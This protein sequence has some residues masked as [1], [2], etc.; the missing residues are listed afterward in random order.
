ML[1]GLLGALAVTA[2]GCGGPNP[3]PPPLPP[4]KPP[5][6]DRAIGPLSGLLTGAGLQWLVLVKPARL[7]A[8]EWLQQPLGRILKRERLAL[9]AR[10]TGIDVRRCAELTLAGYQDD[11]VAYLV[12]HRSD[13]TLVE[14]RFRER[15]TSDVQR[16]EIDR[17][18]LGL[19]GNIGTKPHGFAALGPDVAAF[20]YGGDKKRGPARIALLYAQGKLKKVP[21]ALGGRW[22]GAAHRALGDAPAKLLLPGP[23]E[24]EMAAGLRGLLGGATA[25]GAALTP[26]RS[27]SLRF[28][29]VLT[30]SWPMDAP[31]GERPLD[32]L[33][34][35]WLDL[36]KSDLGHLL[37]L[38]E[39]LSEPLL[40]AGAH[41]L[42][43]AVE[44]DAAKLFDGLAAATLDDVREFMRAP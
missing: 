18:L 4:P 16:A 38:H 17:Q 2:L 33:R 13:Q 11:V 23:F 39:P 9:L 22:L 40:S 25:L 35:A 42:G 24:D 21:T 27:N 3:K 29:A 26:T 5:E 41:D 20:Q 44:L 30:G 10:T 14:R 36:E 15:L 31:R 32:Y 7:A 12:R 1:D 6:P 8:I 19:W 34:A 43:V 37:H 28:D